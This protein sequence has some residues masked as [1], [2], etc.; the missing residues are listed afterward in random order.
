MTNQIHISCHTL[1]MKD[2]I[3]CRVESDLQYLIISGEPTTDELNAAWAKISDEFFDLA[4]KAQNLYA[5]ELYMELEALHYKMQVVSECVEIMRSYRCEELVK[6]L[7]DM[8]YNYPFDAEDEVKYL[9]DLDRVTT[10]AKA[11]VI[12]YNERSARLDILK[13]KESPDQV[14]SYQYYDKILAVLSKFNGY[15]VDE[16][17]T[18]VSRY[19]ALL[20]LYISYC[21]TVD[22]K[23]EDAGRK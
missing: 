2:F 6:L 22:N 17:T 16:N 20:N 10:R 5:L 11:L 23:L 18:T 7:K 21:E 3:K 14:E 8:G 12:A 4:E 19:A 15:H 1:L 9:K 13:E